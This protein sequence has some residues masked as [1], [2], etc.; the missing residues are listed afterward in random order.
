MA[1]DR[2]AG[3]VFT[4]GKYRLHRLGDRWAVVWNDDAGIR[5]RYRLDATR[6]DEARQALERF[7]RGQ[8]LIRAHGAKT[9][10]EIWSAYVDD[11]RL[12]GKRSI[13]IMAYNW[14]ALSPRFGHLLPAMID[15]RTCMEYAA[16]RRR[17]GRKEATILTELRRIRNALNWAVKSEI[18]PK[19]PMIWLPAEPRSR[20]RWMTREEVHALIDAASVSP[21]VR[22]YIIL[23][24]A[25]A[26][27]SEALL[28]LTWD[29][30]DFTART[31]ALDDPDRLRTS[32]GRA[33]VPMN[34][35]ARAALTV[36]RA[37][38]LTPYVIEWK[39]DRVRSIKKGFAAAVA[40][41][42]ITHC[43]PHDLRRTAASWMVMDGVPIEDVARYLGHK[44]PRITWQVYGRFSPSHLKAA[45]AAVDLD[46]RK[47][48]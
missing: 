47:A 32:K 27:R 23:G 44:S 5:R 40:R 48:V 36:T 39:Q 37:G 38:A 1:G 21:H 22:L 13:G 24:I 11:R 2:S 46:L 16:A 20:E 30:I 41:S 42:G 33:T 14:K 4:V 18:I 34:D 7:A 6:Q 26:G 43:T 31:I 3:G 8:D 9:V 29:R 45:S 15:K 35:M 17:E 28:D 10:S 12:E 25:T 19:A